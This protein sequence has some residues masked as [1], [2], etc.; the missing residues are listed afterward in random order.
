M[1]FY[2]NIP[3]FNGQPPIQGINNP[4]IMNNDINYKISELEQR[5]KR[6]EQRISR[7]E[8]DKNNNNYT[9]PDNSL[10]MI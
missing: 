5:I 9:E 2:D 7:L 1:N 6:L 3:N 8:V 4:M 10:Y